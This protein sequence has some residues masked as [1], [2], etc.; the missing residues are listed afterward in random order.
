LT[1]YCSDRVDVTAELVKILEDDCYFSVFKKFESN[2]KTPLQMMEEVLILL[3]TLQ[4]KLLKKIELQNLHT[5]PRRIQ[6]P[7]YTSENPTKLLTKLEN[8]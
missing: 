4:V 8:I 1:T 5:I 3:I 7:K 2:N 6:D